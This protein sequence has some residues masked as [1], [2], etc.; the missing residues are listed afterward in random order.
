MRFSNTPGTSVFPQLE[1]LAS[2]RPLH[3]VCTP[4]A[5]T[6]QMVLKSRRIAGAALSLKKT[7]RARLQR[8]PLTVAHVLWLEGLVCS[9]PV[10]FDCVFAGCLLFMLH[11][12]CRYS[13]A[14]NVDTE[15]RVDGTWIESETSEFKTKNSKGQKDL[16]LPLVGCAEG[17]SQRPWAQKWLSARK[18]LGLRARPGYPFMPD[19]G[20]W[21]VDFCFHAKSRGQ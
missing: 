7:K 3:S 4:L 13:D 19:V 9:A 12:R 1:F 18:K 17:L 2:V 11:C 21:R 20:Y 5:S 14:M 6:S 16:V 15:P 10:G 8:P